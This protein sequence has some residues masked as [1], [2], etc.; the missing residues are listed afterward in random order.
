[1]FVLKFSATARGHCLHGGHGFARP[2]PRAWRLQHVSNAWHQPPKAQPHR[3]AKIGP[4]LAILIVAGN[5]S[6]PLAVLLGYITL[7]S[8][9]M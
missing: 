9:G 4:I 2:A 5:I 8:Q 6:M 1:M 7:P 3:P